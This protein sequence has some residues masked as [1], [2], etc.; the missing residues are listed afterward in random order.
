MGGRGTMTKA[1]L[2]GEIRDKL[3]FQLK[4]SAK[5]VESVLDIMKDSLEAGEKSR[6]LVL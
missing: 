5:L 2:A 1:D 3:G 6:Y 4:E